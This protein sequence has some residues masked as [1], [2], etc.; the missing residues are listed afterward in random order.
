ML[1]SDRKTS[2]LTTP[3][4]ALALSAC[5]VLAGCFR[6]MYADPAV[7]GAPAAGSAQLGEQMKRIDISPIANRTGISL[8][9]ELIFAFTGTGTPAPDRK[10][11]LDVT[12]QQQSI[13]QQIE[14]ISTR[15][16]S[17]LVGITADYVLVD[18]ATGSKLYTGRTFARASYD[19]DVQRFANIRAE[20]EAEDRATR[21]IAEGIRNGIAGY[22]ARS[23]K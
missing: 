10:Y 12:L 17:M 15:N 22:F 2:R 1:S 21:Q 7:M 20:R 19:R 11:R 5:L 3:R 18:V 6:P 4:L 13:Q 9:N 14:P 23:A 8:R 16:M